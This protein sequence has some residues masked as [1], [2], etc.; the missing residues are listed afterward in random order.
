MDDKIIVSN[1]SA[2]TAKYGAAGVARI[3][4]AVN[5]LIAAD[6]ARGILTRL[7]YLDDA[8]AMKS[9]RGKP[10]LTATDPRQN[11]DAIDAI[12]RSKTPQYLTIL[13]AIDVV[14]HQDLTNPLYDPKDDS[15]RVAFGDLP[16]A[17]DAPYSRDIASFKGPTRVVGRLPD[18]TGARH[19]T[20]I[21]VLLEAAAKHKSRPA[22]DYAA[23]FGLSTY[24]WRKSTE[25]SLSNV[26]GSSSAL[27]VSPPNGP[28][29]PAA[30]L[31]PLAHF[32]NCHGGD[33]D[34]AFYGQKGSSYPDSLSSKTVAGKIRPGTVAAVECCYGAQLYDSVTLALPPPICQQY[35]DQGAYGYLGSS[36]IA[37]GPATGNG[38]ADL[39][40]QYFLLA[41]LDGASLGRA[42]LLARQQFVQQ[43]VELD[44]ADLKTLGQFNLLGDPS[45]QPVVL[46]SA[47]AV[48]RGTDA[49]AAARQQRQERRA[50]LQAF[51]DFL[52]GTKPT[53]SKKAAAGRRSPSVKKALAN[54]ARE[55]GIGARREFTAYAVKTPRRVGP[56][57]GKAAPGASRYFVAV[58]RRSSEDYSVAAVAKEVNGRIVGYRIYQEKTWRAMKGVPSESRRSSVA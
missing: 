25:L 16:Y 45:I 17:C 34:P 52:Q 50:K 10:V 31:A 26:F 28:R 51:G 47:T 29:H 11:K 44:P 23:Y 24:A 30:R 21:L 32:I 14:P 42:A 38:A 37:Y 7:V 19:P 48:P 43:T 36:T 2:L 18:L 55:A 39:I 8:A 46:D 13:G 57:R 6:K 54:I 20:H 1:K 22:A 56:S 12:F 5:A 40:T 33:T 58:Y 27:T 53:A 15:D 41:I 9:C 49:P 35:L 3:K 4:A